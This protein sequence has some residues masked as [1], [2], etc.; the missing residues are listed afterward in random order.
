MSLLA[1]FMLAIGLSMDAFSVAICKGLS[2]KKITV[3]KM[4]VVGTWFGLFQAMMPL[5]GYYL[6]SAFSSAIVK[7]DHWIAF[8][9]LS[10]IGINMIKE[11]LE[12]EVET[13][14]DKNTE[15]ENL[16]FKEMFI[17]AVA[18]SIDALACGIT[19]A[20][21]KVDIWVAVSLIGA[22]TF[23]FG[24]CGVKIGNVFGVKYK[25]KA[26]LAGGIILIVLGVKILIE[27]LMG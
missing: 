26:E 15:T 9:L 13:P 18:T 4:L 6:G 17:L 12:K 1:I 20:F 7:I 23:V 25:S 22:T 5:I 10:F 27:H 19:F 24:F 3:A 16:S 8:V 14:G 21:L 2:M 11:A